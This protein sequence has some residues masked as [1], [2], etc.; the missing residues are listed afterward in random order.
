M[1]I[2]TF[3][4][5]RSGREAGFDAVLSG[6]GFPCAKNY[7]GPVAGL[8]L[9]GPIGWVMRILGWAQADAEKGR[10]RRFHRLKGSY[11]CVP[12]A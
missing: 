2:S 7:Y 1:R 4:R 10:G 9:A 12:R 6:H 3:Q 8:P 11:G 5:N